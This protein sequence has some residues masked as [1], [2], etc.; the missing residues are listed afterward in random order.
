VIRAPIA[1]SASAKAAAVRAPCVGE[2]SD[3]ILREL[4][5]SDNA[6]AAFRADSII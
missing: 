5:Y 3:T 4:G 1:L 2:H 6:I